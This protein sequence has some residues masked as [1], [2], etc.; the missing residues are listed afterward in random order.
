MT[1]PQKE[2]DVE[3]SKLQQRSYTQKLQILMGRK[4]SWIATCNVIMGQ[5]E[6]KRLNQS[7]KQAQKWNCYGFTNEKTPR[8]TPLHNQ[9]HE[10]ITEFHT[11]MI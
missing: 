9:E 5:K 3:K 2:E 4:K 6:R 10:V 8:D 7:S 11:C 1:K